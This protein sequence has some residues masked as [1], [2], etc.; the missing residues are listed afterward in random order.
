MPYHLFCHIILR[1]IPS[2][3]VNFGSWC[4]NASA[5]VVLLRTAWTTLCQSSAT[6][7]RPCAIYHLQA[8]NS[9]G[10]AKFPEGITKLGEVQKLGEVPQI[11]QIIGPFEASLASR[12]KHP[13]PSFWIFFWGAGKTAAK[14]PSMAAS[15]T[16]NIYFHPRQKSS[17]AQYWIY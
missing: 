2:S 16:T 3:W 10:C 11:I 7:Q 5:N 8:H 13:H 17:I 12:F 9:R 15:N 14:H 6:K 4:A 1:L